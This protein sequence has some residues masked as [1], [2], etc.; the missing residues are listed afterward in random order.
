M[1]NLPTP[2]KAYSIQSHEA[3]YHVAVF[4]RES[5]EVEDLLTEFDCGDGCYDGPTLASVLTGWTEFSRGPGRAFGSEPHVRVG[6]RN[7]VVKQFVS[8][9]I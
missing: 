6:R 2:R 8:L 7:V 1:D 3:T 9:D 4:S 5:D